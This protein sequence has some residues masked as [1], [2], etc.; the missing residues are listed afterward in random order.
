M[1]HRA[2]TFDDVRFCSELLPILRS[3]LATGVCSELAAFIERN[4][5]EL[6]DPNRG[7]PV[8]CGWESILPAQDAHQ[9]G[10]LAITRYYEPAQN[11]GLADR[12]EVVQEIWAADRR[13]GMSPI[14][15]EVVE[16]DGVIFDPGQSGSYFQSAAQVRAS[17]GYVRTIA[18]HDATPE[19]VDAATMLERAV[20]ARHGLYV[21]F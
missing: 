18:L 11:I 17:L 20:R 4:L 3:A 13:L 12:W 21:T 5:D 1:E 7:A 14:L 2:Y 9:Y 16:S 6:K 10:R 19:L 8:S 15:G